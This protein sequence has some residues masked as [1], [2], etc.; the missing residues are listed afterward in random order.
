M[1]ANKLDSAID[2]YLENRLSES[3]V[4]E[5]SALIEESAEARERYWEM[6]SI[7]GLLEESLQSASLKAV[8][9]E[10]PVI[11]MKPKFGA[12]WNS[13]ASAVAGLMVGVFGATMLWAYKGSAPKAELREEVLFESFESNE[14]VALVSRFPDRAGEWFG[15][16]TTG[17]P[18]ME[19]SE[20]ER[21]DSVAKFTPNPDRK[22]SYARYIIDVEGL[23]LS[24]FAQSPQLE[25]KASFASGQEVLPA[26][27]QIRLAAFSQT[28]D[29]VRAIWNHEAVLFETVLQHTARNFVAKPGTLG[30][31]K[32]VSRIDLPTGTRSVVISLGVAGPVG[33]SSS[34][35]HYLDA[36]RARLVSSL[37]PQS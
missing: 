29:E 7:H 18:P 30:W 3:E 9:S 31:K 1:K 20:P 22:Y 23:P 24:K 34:G 36:V 33:S 16:L 25:V 8:T 5:L 37:A 27:Y 21:G 13:I 35:S 10:A 14:P 32:L 6:A 17:L 26:R 11:P 28:P 12:R 15:N 4:E 19:G 2:A